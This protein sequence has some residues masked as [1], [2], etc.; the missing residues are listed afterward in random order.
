MKTDVQVAWSLDLVKR[1]QDS[2]PILSQI[3]SLLVSEDT[4]PE[5]VD[6][7][8]DKDL[9]FV[10]K[11][12]S[13]LSGGEDCILRHIGTENYETVQIVIPRSLTSNDAR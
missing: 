4:P 6:E 3:K 5:F 10:Y 11:K 9:N 1:Q 7:N 2:C 13:N 8:Q 12:M